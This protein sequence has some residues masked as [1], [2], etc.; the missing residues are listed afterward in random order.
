MA[1]DRIMNFKVPTA[2]IV[3]AIG[4]IKAD[5]QK[6]IETWADKF[7]AD[8]VG[9]LEWSDRTFES[10]ARLGVVQY[11]ERSIKDGPEYSAQQIVDFATDELFRKANHFG[12]STAL[13]SNVLDHRT[14]EAWVREAREFY[15]S[16]HVA[17]AVYNLA[18]QAD[19]ETGV[20]VMFKTVDLKE[21]R[22]KVG[23]AKVYVENIDHATTS[24][25]TG[26]LRL[27]WEERV[28]FVE[29]ARI[30]GYSFERFDAED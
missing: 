10:V 18:Y 7:K 13:A 15:S 21:G 24:D 17:G 30:N 29:F 25:R 6:E 26:A 4:E 19:R 3:E 14:V 9:S 11:I 20:Y 22:K 5:L 23:T 1:N 2:R 12:R 8:P 28:S 16:S 27:T